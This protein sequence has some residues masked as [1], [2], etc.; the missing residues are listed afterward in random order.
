M[1]NTKGSK[2][3]FEAKAKARAALEARLSGQPEAAVVDTTVGHVEGPEGTWNTSGVELPV[4]LGAV[5]DVRPETRDAVS[6]EGLKELGVPVRTEADRAELE[7]Q[8]EAAPVSSQD[9]IAVRRLDDELLEVT[10][11]APEKEDDK[12]DKPAAKKASAKKAS[13]R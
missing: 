2:E 1:A 11:N 6:L 13:S 9:T 10:G 5:R 7:A 3:W 8:A 12:A 4:V